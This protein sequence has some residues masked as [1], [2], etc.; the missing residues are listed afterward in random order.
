MNRITSPGYEEVDLGRLIGLL[1]D[2][3]WL[4]LFITVVFAVVGTVYAVLATP[5]YRGDALVQ[6]ERRATVNPLEDIAAGMRGEDR[7]SS[8]AAEVQILQSRMVL[9]QVVDRVG[10][11]TVV[12]P[13][14]LPI[15]GSYVQRH[16]IPRPAF[17]TASID[18]A[19]FLPSSIKLPR[20][21]QRDSFLPDAMTGSISLPDDFKSGLSL[22]GFLRGRSVVWGGEWLELGRLEVADHLRGIPLRVV[23]GEGGRYTL[24][25]DGETPRALGEARVGELARFAE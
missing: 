16:Q 3:K 21:M 7:E 23:A 22:P 15:V 2:S 6:V 17:A 18:I 4:I 14:S 25:L 24:S 20:F 19:D 9:G 11:D 13:K 1:V 8:T 5:I 12:V 10:L